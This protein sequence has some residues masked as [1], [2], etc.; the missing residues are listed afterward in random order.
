MRQ[1]TIGETYTIT[2]FK[3]YLENQSLL[4]KYITDRS[5]IPIIDEFGYY[6]TRFISLVNARKQKILN[7]KI[8]D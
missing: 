4:A 3:G 7:L 6:E 1:L 2:M 8:N 5:T